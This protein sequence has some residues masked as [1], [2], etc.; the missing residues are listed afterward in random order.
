MRPLSLALSI[1][2][3]SFGCGG[4]TVTSQGGAAGAGAAGG[5]AGG[6][7]SDASTH[8]ADGAVPAP[9]NSADCPATPPENRTTCGHAY[10]SCTWIDPDGC[11]RPYVCMY[12]GGLTGVTTGPPPPL[13]WQ[14][15]TPEADEACSTPGLVCTYSNVAG[16]RIVCDA[17]KWRS[18]N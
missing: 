18:A 14:A 2:S 17:G 15:S 1:L 13:Q 6:S 3:L 4:N 5:G 10:L 12:E 8:G 11:P 7:G 16:V 9:G